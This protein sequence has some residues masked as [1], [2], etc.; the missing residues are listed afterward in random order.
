MP[1]QA[2]GAAYYVDRELRDYGKFFT[3]ISNINMN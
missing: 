2:G 3:L 1:R